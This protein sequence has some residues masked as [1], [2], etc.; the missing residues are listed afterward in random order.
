MCIRDRSRVGG[1]FGTR[2]VCSLLRPTEENSPVNLDINVGYFATMVARQPELLRRAE[3]L[4]YRCIWTAEAY[5]SDAATPLAAIGAQT[6]T[7]EIGSA[8]LQMPARTPAMTAMTAAT[9]DDLTGG[10]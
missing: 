7:L 8:I 6:T 2:Q 1:V 10:R 9:L 5:G 4:G 3:Q